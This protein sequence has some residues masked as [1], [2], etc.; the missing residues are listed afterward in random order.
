ME[1]IK[2]NLEIVKD[3]VRGAALIAITDGMDNKSV[4]K[5]VT[6]KD[7]EEKIAQTKLDIMR[8]FNVFFGV[9]VV[10]VGVEGIKQLKQLYKIVDRGIDIENVDLLYQAI[11]TCMV[12]L[13]RNIT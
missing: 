7:L 4:G 2:R 10:G 8:E 13:N 9:F 12:D 3:K 1:D 5:G 6:L 11:A